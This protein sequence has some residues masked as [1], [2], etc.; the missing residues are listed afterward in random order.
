MK[1]IC[2]RDNSFG[3]MNWDS[4]TIVAANGLCK[5][6]NSFTFIISFISTMNAMSIIRLISV[7]LQNRSYDIVKAYNK[8]KDVKKELRAVRSSDIML[9]SWYVQAESLASEVNVI[10]QVPRTTG[11]QQHRSNVEHDSVEEY[12][13]RTIILPLLDHLIQQMEERFGN[14]QILV[15]K[16]INLVPSVIITLTEISY[17]DVVSFY[18]DDL[19]N[20]AVVVMEVMRWKEKWSSEDSANRPTDLQTA[21][22]A[23]DKDDFPNIFVFLRIACTVPV[24]SCENER[25]NSTLKNLKTFLRNNMGQERLSSLAL[26]H[27]HYSSAIDF[28]DVIDNFKLK[29]KRRITL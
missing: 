4:K 3:D 8:V 20:P 14:T 26:M 9:H 12:Y 19:P 16:L 25:A 21:L 13:R 22:K 29:C 27:I 23:C 18:S 2:E 24:T 6:Y 11:R 7:K 1:A 10:P 15:A 17:N 5:M 28:D